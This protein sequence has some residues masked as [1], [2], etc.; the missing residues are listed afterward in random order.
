VPGVTEAIPPADRDA[1]VADAEAALYASRICAYAQGMSLIRTASRAYGWGID[2]AEI[3]R[4]WTGG[5]IIRARLLD[6][7]RKAFSD[8]P[9]IANLL[10]AGAIRSEMSGI[11]PSW[12]RIVALA[13]S[14][15]IPMPAHAAALAYFDSYRTARLPQNLTQAQ[16]D[17]FGAHTYVRTDRPGAVHSDW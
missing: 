11:Q 10:I 9:D 3:A 4:I 2:R 7:I 12:R 15:G 1:V 5:C 14:A 8:S 6:P 17:A 13:A 16:R